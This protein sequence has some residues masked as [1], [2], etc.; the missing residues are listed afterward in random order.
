MHILY[1]YAEISIKGGTDKILVE[2]AN[3]LVNNGFEVTIITESQMGKPL[4]FSLDDKVR[5][6]DMGLDFNRQYFQGSIK[7]LV[8]YN[9]LMKIF[10]NKL[11][12]TLLDLHPDITI[13]VMGRSLSILPFIDDGSIKIGEAH[14][15]KYHLRSLHLMEQ[16]GGFYWLFAKYMRWKMCR[17][18]SKLNVLVLLTNNDAYDWKDIV[19]TYVI[20]NP[21]SFYPVEAAKLENKQVIMVGRYNDAKGYDYLIPA[22]EIVNQRHPDWILNVYGSGELHD[23]VVQWV[24]GANLQ[25]SMILHDPI[26]NI[27]KEYLESSIC[28]LSSR[29]EGFSLVILEAMA[30]GV[31]VVSFDCPHGPRNI[32]K[33]G[34]DGL[35][36]EYLN[37]QAL[38][39]GLCCLI[40]DKE[41]RKHLGRKARSNIMRY[42]KETVMKQWVEL[43]KRI[44]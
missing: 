12:Q 17:C 8:T 32:I 28:V 36:V 5:H 30:C 9:S 38:A 18:A 16:R 21:I 2:K 23:D 40:E 4:S 39:D 1:I 29:Y 33:N 37:S 35:L 11:R 10:K 15:T 26:D 25:D 20:P 42:S 41:K 22:W 19:K 3:W 34:E 24:K 7:R 6:I 13:T 31:P 14:T 43:F 27:M 44:V